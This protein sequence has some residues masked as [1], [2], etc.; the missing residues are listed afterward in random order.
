MP[1]KDKQP[2]RVFVTTFLCRDVEPVGQ[3]G[4]DRGVPLSVLTSICSEISVEQ[5][6]QVFISFT[7][8]PFGPQVEFIPKAYLVDQHEEKVEGT[9]LIHGGGAISLGVGGGP[10]TLILTLNFVPAYY[11]PYWLRVD[12]DDVLV[13]MTPIVVEP[14]AY[15][16]PGGRTMMVPGA[17]TYTFLGTVL[18][19][20][21]E[22]VTIASV[23]EGNL[24][25]IVV[26][27]TTLDGSL[28]F[29]ASIRIVASRIEVTVSNASGGSHSDVGNYVDRLVR[30]LLD[31]YGYI[32]GHAYD[33][34]IS[35]YIDHR[36][37][38]S[39]NWVRPFTV[40]AVNL[41]RDLE[42]TFE[43]LLHIVT[44]EPSELG[45]ETKARAVSQL[46]QALADIREAIRNPHDTAL[47]CYRAIEDIR[48]CYV[49]P[50]DRRGDEVVTKPSWERMRGQLR[51]EESWIKD[52]ASARRPQAHGDS[53][54]LSGEER[55]EFVRRAR[56][57]VDRFL[58]SMQN[59]FRPLSDEF[60]VLT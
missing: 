28:S 21:Q 38:D 40:G 48:Q 39:K 7:N 19:A 43:D 51:F 16:E 5:S 45:D 31:A 57:V 56:V 32:Q 29:D 23:R 18:R 14:P 2:P 24:E 27:S 33:V 53:R 13:A 30:I 9:D 10:L 15:T 47:H 60:E 12:L 20:N 8:A 59:G 3:Q 11:G 50:G 1:A 55:G 36:E 44:L 35:H 46:A 37:L 17:P 34:F 22:P 25:P 41:Q 42:T 54:M 49:E 6:L 26:F 52:I 4:G 58:A